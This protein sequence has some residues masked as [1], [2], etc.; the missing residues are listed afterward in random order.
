MIYLIYLRKLKKDL[1]EL[2]G[3]KNYPETGNIFSPN[4]SPNIEA[5]WPSK[6]DIG[7]TYDERQVLFANNIN[8]RV[9]IYRRVNVIFYISIFLVMVMGKL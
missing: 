9:I 2:T 4:F 8:S 5:V 6:I 7:S 3:N 1:A